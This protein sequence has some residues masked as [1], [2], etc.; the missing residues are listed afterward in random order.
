MNGVFEFAEVTVIIGVFVGVTAPVGGFVDGMSRLQAVR[1]D[2]ARMH[3]DT[4]NK[5]RREKSFFI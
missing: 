3:E 2:T 4:F 5:S 1:H